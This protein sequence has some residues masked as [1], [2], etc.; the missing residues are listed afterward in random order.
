MPLTPA[1]RTLFKEIAL[2]ILVAGF[3]LGGL[4][5]HSAPPTVN[6]AGADSVSDDSS[7]PPEDTRRY[8]HDT[9][10]NLGQLG[11]LVDKSGRAVAKLA[12]P[13]PLAITIIVVLPP[14]GG[15]VLHR[16]GAKRHGGVATGE[17]RE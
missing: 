3:C 7:L 1:R 6:D 2:V 5:Y 11:L 12:Q 17:F 14:G 13:R 9:E 10:V 15:W 4:V 8:S 16:G